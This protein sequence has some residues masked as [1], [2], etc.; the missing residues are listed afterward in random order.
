MRAALAETVHRRGEQRSADRGSLP[1]R[2]HVEA[3]DVSHPSRIVIVIVGWAVL[4]EA[5]H[6]LIAPG[7]QHPATAGSLTAH[8]IAPIAESVSSEP[9]AVPRLARSIPIRHLPG[10]EVQ[11]P[12]RCGIGRMCG[13]DLHVS[14]VTEPVECLAS[15]PLGTAKAL[16]RTAAERQAATPAARSTRPAPADPIAT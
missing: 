16:S 10:G 6:Q 8:N 1:C 14:R 4:A 15:A 11:I 13:H 12:Q 7:D 5:D 3:M 9:L 2:M